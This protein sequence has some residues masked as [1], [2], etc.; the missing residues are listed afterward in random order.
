MATTRKIR[1][2]RNRAQHPTLQ[3]GSA[4]LRTTNSKTKNSAKNPR[5]K[6]AVTKADRD[7]KRALDVKQTTGDTPAVVPVQPNPSLP[8]K[9]KRTKN[10]ARKKPQVAFSSRQY[11][12]KRYRKGGTSGY[13]SYG[14][15]AAFKAHIINTFVQANNIKRVIDFGCGDGHQLSLFTFP[16]YVGID[17]SPTS[18]SNCRARFHKDFTKQFLTLAEYNNHPLKADLTLSL[19]VIF[20]LVEDSVFE[21]YMNLLFSSSKRHCIVYSCNDEQFVS[22]DAHVKKRRFTTWI[23]NRLP[24]WQL[25]EVVHNPYPHI[26]EGNSR[27]NSF[28]DFYFYARVH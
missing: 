14:R 23:T 20:H 12:E 25:A 27:N 1:N 13:G 11:W 22:P 5:N 17:V 9:P 3:D 18:V 7:Q 16:R 26:G 19:D 10:K 2:S 21:S 6:R 15:L 8:R 4:S 24:H 28:S